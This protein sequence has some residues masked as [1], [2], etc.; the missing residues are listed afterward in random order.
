MECSTK[1]RYPSHI[2]IS[3]YKNDRSRKNHS[4]CS[5]INSIHWHWSKWPGIILISILTPLAKY[6][7]ST[8][9]KLTIIEPIQKYA[10]PSV[11]SLRLS[12]SKARTHRI[13]LTRMETGEHLNVKPW[14][15]FHQSCL[16][17]LRRCLLWM[18]W[19]IRRSRL[20]SHVKRGERRR[21]PTMI[22]KK[23]TIR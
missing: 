1:K 21:W 10:Y 17:S 4:I 8:M 23:R 22:I 9:N 11:T 7:H 20:C 5:F 19:R 18:R 13:T 12:K 14:A 16:L 6:H 15:G 3:T 2:R